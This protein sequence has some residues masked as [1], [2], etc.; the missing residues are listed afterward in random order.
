MGPRHHPRCDPPRPTPPSPSYTVSLTWWDLCTA[1][2]EILPVLHL[3]PHPTTPPSPGGTSVP[4]TTRSSPSYSSVPILH[5]RPHLVGSLCRPRRDPP[6]PTAPFPSY[7]AA[8]TWWDIC[9]IHDAVLPVL[10]LLPHPTPP[11]SP[12]GTS[13]P[14]TTRSVRS[15][16]SSLSPLCPAG[17]ALSGVKSSVSAS[18][19]VSVSASVSAARTMALKSP[20]GSGPEVWWSGQVSVR[21]GPVRVRRLAAHC[22]RRHRWP[23]RG[24]AGAHRQPTQ[25]FSAAETCHVPAEQTRVTSLLPTVTSPECGTQVA[26]LTSYRWVRQ[27]VWWLWVEPETIDYV[28]CNP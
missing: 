3:P 5:R 17:A 10:H 18:T 2:D 12:G 6:H 11:P 16:G 23:G 22:R 26:E 27:V 25:V 21:G 15:S 28:V 7:A 1:H 4:P 14:P 19:G 20:S 13:V 24:R 9:A 8:L